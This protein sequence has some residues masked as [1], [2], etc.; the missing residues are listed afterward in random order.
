MVYLGGILFIVVC[1]LGKVTGATTLGK[2]FCGILFIISVLL[3][4]CG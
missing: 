3:M 4:C 2:I 1:I